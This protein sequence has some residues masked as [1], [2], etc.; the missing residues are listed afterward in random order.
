M[1]N[2]NEWKVRD[3]SGKTLAQ[4]LTCEPFIVG[5]KATHKA[6]NGAV[7]IQSIGSGTENLKLS[8]LCEDLTSKVTIDH[9]NDDGFMFNV[10]YRGLRYYGYIEEPIV[11]WSTIVP[12]SIY[13]GTCILIIDHVVEVDNV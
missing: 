9:L 5:G 12:G 1:I 7:Y 8:I 2:V 4:V 10:T 13:T 6:L 3:P 11:Q